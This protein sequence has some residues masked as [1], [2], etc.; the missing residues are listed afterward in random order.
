MGEKRKEALRVGFDGG[1]KLA[2]CGSR[3]TSDAG[4]VAYR[5][6]D[7]ALGLTAM[8]DSLLEDQRTGNNRQHTLTAQLRQSIFSRLAGY[9]DTNDAERL[10]VD[11]AMR[12][13]VGGRAKR[14]HAASTSQMSRFETDVLT[15]TTHLAALMDLSGRWIDAVHERRPVHEIILDLDSSVSETYGE[16]RRFGVQRPLWLYLLPPA[17]L[18]QP[19]RRSRTG[20]APQWQRGQRR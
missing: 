2:F 12:H 9:E 16:T 4:L 18:L 14:K 6:L 19:V 20:V 11:P 8:A 17:V 7:D 10:A 13:V 1:L 3:V 5:D 15:Q